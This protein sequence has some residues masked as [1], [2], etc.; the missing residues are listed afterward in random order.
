MR[1]DEQALT[2]DELIKELNNKSDL[3]SNIPKHSIVGLVTRHPQKAMI[4]YLALLKS[5]CVPCIFDDR[6]SNAQTFNLVEKYGVQYLM[7]EEDLRIHNVT[8]KII[9]RTMTICYISLLHLERQAYLK[10]IIGSVILD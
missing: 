6:W 5:E 8:K 9:S 2:Y 10:H 4:I 3:F 7:E 1:F